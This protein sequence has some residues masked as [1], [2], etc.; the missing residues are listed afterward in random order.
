MVR[1]CYLNRYWFVF[2]VSDL[3]W[4]VLSWEC[5]FEFYIT[6]T[7]QFCKLLKSNF[8]VVFFL[9]R[10]IIEQSGHVIHISWSKNNFNEIMN[11]SL[12]IFHTN[13]SEEYVFTTFWWNSV[14]SICDPNFYYK[15]LWNSK[16]LKILISFVCK[17]KVFNQWYWLA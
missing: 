12:S 13:Q 7:G 8:F 3:F 14:D 4:F 2:H 1:A 15:L 11:I 16:F 6:H 10:N 9:Y 5:M 17:K